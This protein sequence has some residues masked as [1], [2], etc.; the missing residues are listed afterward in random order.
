MPK[1]IQRK[2]TKGWKVPEGAVYVGRPTKWGNPFSLKACGTRS[3]CVRLYRAWLAGTFTEKS[4]E[5][6][7]GRGVKVEEQPLAM[8]RYLVIRGGLRG[9]LPELR[10]KDLMCWCPL[11]Q[12]CHADVLL[13]LANAPVKE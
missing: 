10:G 11:D 12:P 8:F 7:I 6:I 5:R 3:K 4:I 9:M 2:R 1:R 13:E